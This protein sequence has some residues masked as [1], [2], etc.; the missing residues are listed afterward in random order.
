ML[1]LTSKKVQTKT[2][3]QEHN[4]NNGNQIRSSFLVVLGTGDC[5]SSADRRRSTQRNHDRVKIANHCGRGA[6]HCITSKNA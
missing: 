4:P 2:R 6:Q 5:S 3:K 1:T